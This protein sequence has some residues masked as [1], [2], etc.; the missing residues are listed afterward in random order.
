[1]NQMA[2]YSHL[3]M[4]DPES[5]PDQSAAQLRNA[6]SQMGMIPNLY[7]VLAESPQTLEAYDTLNRLFTDTSFDATEQTV[8][9]QSISV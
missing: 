9:W 1:M 8:V 4:H 7:R 5:A 2:R 6:E 3:T